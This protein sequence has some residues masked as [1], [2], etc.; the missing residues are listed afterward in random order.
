MAASPRRAQTTLCP[1]EVAKVMGKCISIFLVGVLGGLCMQCGLGL[2]ADSHK[3]SQPPPHFLIRKAG[4][5]GT[6]QGRF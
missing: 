6:V 3:N 2:L 1:L 5:S 4:D